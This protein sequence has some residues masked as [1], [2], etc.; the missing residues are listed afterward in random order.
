MEAQFG[1]LGCEFQ[2]INITSNC[3]RFVCEYAV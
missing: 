3:M 2:E 1:E